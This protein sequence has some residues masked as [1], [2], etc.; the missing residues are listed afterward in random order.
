MQI[1][2]ERCRKV[3]RESDLVCR[4]GGEEFAILL[5][6]SDLR[7][8]QGAAERVYNSIFEPPMETEAGP[9]SITLSIGI[10]TLSE[11]TL[12]LE[13]LL[14]NADLALYMAKEEGRSRTRAWEE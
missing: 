3:L 12:S 10:A 1:L 13:S 9:V 14:K 5:P 6:E 11:K 4:Y 8:A 2:T 7:G